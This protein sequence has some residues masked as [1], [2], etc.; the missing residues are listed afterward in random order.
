MLNEALQHGPPAPSPANSAA[1]TKLRGDSEH[2]MPAR[3]PA[4]PT[5]RARSNV[6]HFRP[7]ENWLAS[8]P[9]SAPNK[10]WALSVLFDQA[11]KLPRCWP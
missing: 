11:Q 3:A 8:V 1:K 10:R 9:K 6:A 2:L 5:L 7:R 4:V